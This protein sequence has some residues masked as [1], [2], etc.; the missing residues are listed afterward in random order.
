MPRQWINLAQ[1]LAL[2]YPRY[3]FVLLN[4]KHNTL[5]INIDE[6]KNLKSFVNDESIASLFYFS[7]KLDYLISVDTGQVHICDILQVPS[8]VLIHEIVANR[9]GNSSYANVGGGIAI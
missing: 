7:S 8:L 2:T 6:S 9:F 1:N 5:Q 4:F 3:L